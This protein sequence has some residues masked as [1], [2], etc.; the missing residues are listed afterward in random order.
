MMMVDDSGVITWNV[1]EHP[2]YLKRETV[3]RQQG[4]EQND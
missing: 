1:R 4:R 3:A 2:I